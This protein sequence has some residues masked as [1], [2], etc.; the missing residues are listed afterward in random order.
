[1]IWGSSSDP[2]M[3]LKRSAIR[4][5]SLKDVDGAEGGLGIEREVLSL[6]VSAGPCEGCTV[7]VGAGEGEGAGAA[8]C[9]APKRFFKGSWGVADTLVSA[10][11]DEGTAA[12]FEGE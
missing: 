11:G 6:G 4:S 7:A 2:G 12:C 10:G 9:Y 1:V 3:D 5:A 8:E